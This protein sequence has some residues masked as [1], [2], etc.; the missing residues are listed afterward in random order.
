[1]GI[2]AIPNAVFSYFESY[3]NLG[4]HS[5][6]FSDGIPPLI[7]SGVINGFFNEKASW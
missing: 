3:K 5:E 6:I 2:G 1:M 7:E 4:I